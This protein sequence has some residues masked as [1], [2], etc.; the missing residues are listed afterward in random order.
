M[1]KKLKKGIIATLAFGTM[2]SVLPINNT[3]AAMNYTVKNGDSLYKIGQTYGVP[4]LRLQSMNQLNSSLIYPGQQL[5]IPEQISAQELDLLA[6]LVH[7]EAKGEPYAGKVAVAT[8]VLNRVDHPDFPDTITEVINGKDHGYY[9]FTPV[10][11]GQINM[12]A[13]PE[14]VKAVKEALAFRGQGNGSLFFYNPKTS[15]S[16]YVATREVTITIGNHVFAK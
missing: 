15:T 12:P 6:R 3:E 11:N 13:D 10:A 7:A 9:A 1:L 8:V 14:S 2:I 5:T 16:G 4:V